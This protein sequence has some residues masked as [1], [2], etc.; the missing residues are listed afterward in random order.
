VR[1]GHVFRGRGLE[2]VEAR[3]KTL[4]PALGRILVRATLE[5]KP[6]TWCK[7]RLS[8]SSFPTT[9]RVPLAATTSPERQSLDWRSGCFC[10][11]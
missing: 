4:R 2:Q 3:P 6:G 11:L 1:L 8:G 10:Y 7:G 5:V 9:L